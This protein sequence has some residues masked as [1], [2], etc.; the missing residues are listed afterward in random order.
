MLTVIR[1]AILGDP[2]TLIYCMYILGLPWAI[3]PFLTW[4]TSKLR[5]SLNSIVTMRNRR[6]RADPISCQF[7]R[8][9]KLRCNRVQPCSNCTVRGIT[10]AFIIPPST[11][12]NEASSSNQALLDRIERLE[13]LILPESQP[14]GT[15][16]LM[17]GA[18]E[19]VWS[20]H[21]RQRERERVLQALEHIESRNDSFVSTF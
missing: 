4:I 15:P 14:E 13:S 8:S 17:L 7:C 10:C 11:Q 2:R 18:D 21:H 12:R 9:K 3:I 6:N 19:T 1:H 5:Q 16:A 20:D